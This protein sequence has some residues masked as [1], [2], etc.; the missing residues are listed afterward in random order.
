MSEFKNGANRT[1]GPDRVQIYVKKYPTAFL[2][3]YCSHTY[4]KQTNRSRRLRTKDNETK[5]LYVLQATNGKQMPRIVDSDPTVHHL[6]LREPFCGEAL[7]TFDGSFSNKIS[8]LVEAVK[9]IHQKAEPYA[10][11]IWFVGLLES[12]IS[13][14]DLGL[15]ACELKINIDLINSRV[16]GKN[17]LTTSKFVISSP[18]KVNDCGV[19]LFRY[20]L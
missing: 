8:S 1:T 19:I 6:T 12:N 7:T 16:V 11:G 9:T 15:M 17:V 13:A 10:K 4:K 14:W 18:S 20:E 3:R 5:T 2:F